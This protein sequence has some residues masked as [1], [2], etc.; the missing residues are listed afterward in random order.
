MLILHQ[1]SIVVSI[2]VCVCVCVCSCVCPH[3]LIFSFYRYQTLCIAS[4]QFLEQLCFHLESG[5]GLSAAYVKDI[6]HEAL[7]DIN[8]EL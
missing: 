3:M 8:C 7:S 2:C 1:G 6:L 5:D 4:N